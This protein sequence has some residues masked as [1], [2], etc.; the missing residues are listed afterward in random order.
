MKGM[1]TACTSQPNIPMDIESLPICYDN[2]ISTKKRRTI[3][4]ILYD[5]KQNPLKPSSPTNPLL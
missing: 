4:C 2:I 5:N 1:I 3:V